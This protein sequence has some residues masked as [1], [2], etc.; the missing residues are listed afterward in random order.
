MSDNFAVLSRQISPAEA[1]HSTSAKPCQDC[2]IEQR[3]RC[4]RMWIV[5]SQQSDFRRQA[6]TIVIDVVA[7]DLDPSRIGWRCVAGQN[8]EMPV[9]GIIEV[10]VGLRG[11]YD[12]MPA[13][14]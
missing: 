1:G 4:T 3:S 13:V 6:V 7:D 2:R 9:K 10:E 5:K 12:L 8:I 14:G 11:Q